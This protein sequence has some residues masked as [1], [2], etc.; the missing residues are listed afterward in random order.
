MPTIS[1]TPRGE[2]LVKNL[3]DKR[4]R[5]L[6]AKPAFLEIGGHVWVLFP[7]SMVVLFFLIFI[8]I[9]FIGISKVRYRSGHLPFKTILATN[10]PSKDRLGVEFPDRS[11]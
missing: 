10:V 2:T 7:F 1:F 8:F 9:Q 11:Q 5:G 6:I 3:C 4:D